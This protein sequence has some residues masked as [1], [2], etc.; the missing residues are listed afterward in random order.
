MVEI[1]EDRVERIFYRAYGSQPS[2]RL[3]EDGEPFATVAFFGLSRAGDVLLAVGVD[4][5]YPIGRDGVAEVEPLPDFEVVGG[6]RVSFDVPGFVLV[7][8]DINQRKSLS[9]SVPLLVP[10]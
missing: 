5:L 4:G 1:C 9:G 8:T 7:L 6:V 10:R 3:N 2:A